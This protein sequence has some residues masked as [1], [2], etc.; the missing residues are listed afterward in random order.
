MSNRCAE[1][2]TAMTYTQCET[3]GQQIDVL[4]NT[5]SE[6]VEHWNAVINIYH[7]FI[8][9]CLRQQNAVINKDDKFTTICL[10]T[11]VDAQRQHPCVC[12]IMILTVDICL[13][14]KYKR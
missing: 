7:K 14:L 4:I 3:I 12:V 2:C 8:N 13:V 6:S 10:G 5:F 11:L 9:F 1:H